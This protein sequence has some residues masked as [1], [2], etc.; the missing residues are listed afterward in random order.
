MPTTNAQ[1][2]RGFQVHKNAA[3]IDPPGGSLVR[4][5]PLKCSAVVPSTRI[6]TPLQLCRTHCF[7]LIT[8]S[9]S[10]PWNPHANDHD[11]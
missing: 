2:T 10:T 8:P 1:K 6:V 7:D 9:T 11:W 3:A 5:V 4:T